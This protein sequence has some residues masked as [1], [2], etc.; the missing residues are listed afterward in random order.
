[1][2]HLP[3]RPPATTAPPAEVRV[4]ETLVAQLLADQ[5]PDLAGL[6]LEPAAEGWDNVIFQLGDDLCVRLPRR[7]LAAPLLLKELDALPALARRLAA[8]GVDIGLPEPVRHGHP[9]RGYPWDW[10]VCRWTAGRPGLAVPAP[11][12]GA[13]APQLSA[14]LI[15]LHTEAPAGAP[16]NPFR[17]GG[18]DSLDM[19]VRERLAR[20]SRRPDAEALGRLWARLRA[21]PPRTGPRRW[22]HGDLHP[23]N[24]LYGPDGRLAAVIDFGDLCA[25]DPAVDLACSWQL[26]GRA[27]RATFRSLVDRPRDGENGPAYD[28]A[29]WLRAAG[30]A[31]HFGL[32]CVGTEGNDPAFVDSGEATL[33]ALLEDFPPTARW[34]KASRR[35]A[36]TA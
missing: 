17:D 32:L 27:D 31:L 9:G 20:A 19:P 8:A 16:A 22:V 28:T 29:C 34:Q 23:G 5:H 26:F 4:T 21:T 12:R 3:H 13:A 2:S 30:W 15:A 35:D 36:P 1:M 11:E 33:A 7:A 25:G 24:L 14:F 10:S 18:L 6:S